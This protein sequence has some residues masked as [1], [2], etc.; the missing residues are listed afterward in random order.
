MLVDYNPLILEL[1]YKLF[2]HQLFLHRYTAV[3]KI[4]SDLLG[5]YFDDHN[6]QVVLSSVLCKI[7]LESM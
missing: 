4:L 7:W 2:L 3:G 1:S 6:E 5:A